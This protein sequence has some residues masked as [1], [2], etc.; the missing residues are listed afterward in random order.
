MESIAGH[1]QSFMTELNE[2]KKN[3][4]TIDRDIDVD[5]LST[6]AGTLKGRDLAYVFK[7][8]YKTLNE[9]KDLVS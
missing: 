6:L 5:N 7:R 2:V 1:Y 9:M 4:L 3:Q 8:A